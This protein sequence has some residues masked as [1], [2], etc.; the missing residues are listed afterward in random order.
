M[1]RLDPREFDRRRSLILSAMPEGSA[2]LVPTNPEQ[3]RSNDTQYRFRPASDF[4][5]L[6]GF[7]EP[8]AWALLRKGLA[9]PSF[10][11][12]VQP[13]DPTKE[14][15]HGVR[16]GTA[17]A[18]SDYGAQ[19]AFSVDTLEPKLA[20]LLGPAEKLYFSFGRDAESEA[21]INGI[22]AKLR[23]GRKAELGPV[24]IEDSATFLAEFRLFKTD[25]ELALMRR[26]AAV[27]AEAHS[28]AMARVRP[29]MY[30]YEL[31]ALI[32]YTFR[33]Q[34][35]WG[36]AYTSIVG[37]GA[38]ACI[39][40]YIEN[41]AKFRQ[42]DLVLIDAGAEIDG[43]ATDVTRTFPVSGKF[44]PP[45]AELYD[46]VLRSQEEAIAATKPGAT[47]GTI[48]DGVVRSL[49]ESMVK[50]GLLDGEVDT[51]IET[52]AYKRYYMHRTSH[53]LGLDVHDVGRYKDEGGHERPLEPGMVLT[54]EPGLYIPA[55]D[56]LAPEAFRG[57]GI[58]IEDDILVTK[59]GHE[60]LT[61]ATP[62]TVAEIE[63]LRA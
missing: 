27:T 33:R 6:C 57:M 54:I 26:G 17:G 9:G 48:H 30:E 42:G 8:G 23:A 58:R 31:D 21:K 1:H 45:Q 43:Y 46:A 20:E 12:F 5:Y 61:A 53:W 18:V 35:A 50:L 28:L 14:V 13:K 2:L 60:N 10:V 38:N 47:I 36:P 40:H 22:L 55:D 16:A 29:G 11:L 4:Y 34:G 7:A 25:A 32:E 52:D 19:E 63:A 49:T 41:N 51:L 15:W 37:G 39:L 3:T 56:E 59:D 62:K 24:S 44:T